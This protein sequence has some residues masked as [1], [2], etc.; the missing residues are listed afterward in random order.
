MKFMDDNDDE[1]TEPELSMRESLFEGYYLFKIYNGLCLF[2]LTVITSIAYPRT[3]TG[4][5][6]PGVGKFIGVARIFSRGALVI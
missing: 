6:F 4:F 2:P 5:F 3:P 1:Q